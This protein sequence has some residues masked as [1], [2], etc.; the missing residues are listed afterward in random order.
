[1][2]AYAFA[3]QSILAP[4]SGL[5][6]VWNTL[7]APCTLGEKLTGKRLIAC[8]LITAG[9]VLIAVF[10]SHSEAEYT[11]AYLEE[12]LLRWQVATYFAIW[13]VRQT[14]SSAL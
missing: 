3:P 10:G 11:A 8:L 12:V 5:D 4:I 13:T 7:L 6:I 9:T 1:M 14:A 2:G